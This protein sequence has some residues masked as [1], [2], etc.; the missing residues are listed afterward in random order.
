[1]DNEEGGNFIGILWRCEELWALRWGD[2]AVE[3][4]G[5]W[6]CYNPAKQSGEVKENKF[7]VP[8][9]LEGQTRCFASQVWAYLVK[10]SQVATCRSYQEGIESSWHI[11]TECPAVTPDRLSFFFQHQI[12]SLPP[13]DRPVSYTHLTL[14]TNREV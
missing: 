4:D 3:D 1:M 14:P 8:F 2:L 13:P 6:V 9:N 12:L 7:M 5:I 11:L 10:Q